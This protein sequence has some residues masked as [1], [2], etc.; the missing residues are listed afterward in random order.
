MTVLEGFRPVLSALFLLE[1]DR[2]G[3]FFGLCLIC[4]SVPLQVYSSKFLGI[5]FDI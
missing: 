4:V 5:V 1:L 2:V 3:L